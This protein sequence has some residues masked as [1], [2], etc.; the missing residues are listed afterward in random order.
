MHRHSTKQEVTWSPT[1]V[2]LRTVPEGLCPWSTRPYRQVVFLLPS[3]GKLSFSKKPLLAGLASS[4]STCKWFLRSTRAVVLPLGPFVCPLHIALPSCSQPGSV[5]RSASGEG[6]WAAL[7]SVKRGLCPTMHAHTCAGSPFPH[8]V[9]YCLF[10][11]FL[12]M[13]TK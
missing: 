3:Q 13:R 6:A 2:D 4:R 10:R 12:S 5:P 9:S 11:T 8:W 7:C 1:L